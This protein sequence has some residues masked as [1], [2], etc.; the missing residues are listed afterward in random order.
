MVRGNRTRTE[1]NEGPKETDRSPN[2]KNH[3]HTPHSEKLLQRGSWGE[4]L[5]REAPWGKG[6]C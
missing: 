4:P 6:G 5:G 2:E 1:T 3:D